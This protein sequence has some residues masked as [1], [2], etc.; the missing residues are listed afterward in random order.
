MY[1][2]IVSDGLIVDACDGMRFVR[3]QERNRM[4]L[5]CDEAGADG[6]LTSDGSTVYLIEGGLVMDGYA[7][8]TYEEITQEEYEE[9]RAEIDAGEEIPNPDEPEPEPEEGPKT[10]LQALEEQVAELSQTNWML[11][12]CLLEM[13]EVVYGGDLL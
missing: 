12:E 10:R 4:M 2:K 3:W 7:T 1:Y 13:S 8:A 11:I 6:I 5:S 9:L